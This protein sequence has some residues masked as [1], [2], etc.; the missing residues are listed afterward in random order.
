MNCI[1]DK[2]Y[3]PIYTFMKSFDKAV[4]GSGKAA[5]LRIG[6]LRDSGYLYRYDAAVYKDGVDDALNVRYTERLLKTLLW[7]VGGYKIYLDCP[8]KLFDDITKIF[9]YGGMRDF[10]VRFMERLYDGK[11]EVVAAGGDAMP[12]EIECSKAVGGNLNGC[13]I[14]FDAGGSDRK[15]S[16]V[17]NG[18]VVFSEETVWNPK[19][20]S[21]PQYHYDGIMDSMKKAA[22]YLP[23]VDAIGVS[24]A[25]VYV[26]NQTRAASLFI[27]VNEADFNR[28]VKNIYIDIAKEFNAAL[29]VANDGDVAALAGAM[30]LNATRVL[31]TAMGTSQAGG[32]IDKNNNIR[33][34]LNELAFVPADVY[35]GAMS[36]EWSGDA[37]CGVK[38]FSQDGVIRLAETAGI[39][40][41]EALTTPAEKLKH[42]QKLNEDGDKR[43]ENVFKDIGVCFGYSVL[44]YSLFYDIGYVLVLGRVTSGK[45]G[46]FLL[47]NALAVLKEHGSAIKIVLPDESSRRVGQSIAAASLPKI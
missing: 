39:E 20:E 4:A 28:V 41:P 30:D 31:G 15:V 24:S 40:F 17:V 12:A 45:G 21:D 36:D 7:I 5:P 42:V 14:G 38:Y 33:G 32:Y 1:I 26:A 3:Q 18:T 47:E 46:V 2:N 8:P 6:L 16:A 35:P 13:R 22:A 25:G 10:D 23:R 29:D 44:H 43:A 9:S 37:G 34:W 11:F 19:L 27:K